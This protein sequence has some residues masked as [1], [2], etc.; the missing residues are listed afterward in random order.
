MSHPFGDPF[1]NDRQRFG[2]ARFER[3]GKLSR[4]DA[5]KQK[6]GSLFV[7]FAGGKTLF[8]DGAG[9]VL[10]VA[11]ARA[12]KLRD[13]LAYNVCHSILKHTLLVLDMK[14]ELA[15]ISQNQTPDKKFCYYWNP[16]GLH[17]LPQHRLNP[18]FH[19]HSRNP[20]LIRDIKKLCQNLVPRSGAPQAEYF[21]ARARE[22]LEGM[23][24]TLV[25]LNG[26]LTLPDLY[27][28]VCLIPGGSD[29]WVEFAFEMIECGY[30][31]SARI[32]EEIFQSREDSSGGAQGILG[33]VFKSV[34]AISDPELRGSISPPFDLSL[35]QLCAK[36]QAVQFY[37]MPPE[38][39]LE[40]WAP[41][42]KAILVGAMTAKSRAPDAPRQTWI[43][44][45]IAK[46][47]KFPLA[48]ELFSFGAGVGIRPVAIYQSIAQAK[49]TGPDAEIIIPSSAACRMY[50]AIRD[51]PSAEAVSR[52][53]GMQTLEYDDPVLQARAKLAEQKALQ[54]LMSGR[55]PVG[56]ALEYDHHK[57]MATHRTKQ[58]RWLRTPDEVLNMKPD[59]AFVF[60][61]GL[62][63][64]VLVTRKP[65][66]TQRF[67][68]GRYHPSPYYP[69]KHKVRVKRLLGSGW[70]PVLIEPVPKAFAHYP[71]YPKGIWSRIGRWGQRAR[72][73]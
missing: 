15:A 39:A 38:D 48:S 44:D 11:G 5:F 73:F 47:Q 27:D 23:I 30:P 12:G 22:F 20:H 40:S 64:P 62:D 6:P 52:M 70:R 13:F 68:A 8:Y 71:Q 41:V 57:Q 16:S 17:G 29:A 56:A 53:L 55:D 1:G 54:A 21:E 24:V 63:H 65:Y 4:I 25:H 32:E 26:Q 67:M 34:A 50:F 31:L 9:G 42:I 2:S 72:R 7:G 66:Y 14:G 35:D 36:D 19:I 18:V 58:Q 37:M 43:L 61:D 45:E 51:L 49:A 3:I 60:M 28:V 10:C 33:E 69:P 59:Q 46:L